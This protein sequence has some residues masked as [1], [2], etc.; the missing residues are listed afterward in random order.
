MDDAFAGKVEGILE[1]SAQLF[2]LNGA[3]REVAVLARSIASVEQT[4]YDNWNGGTSIYTLT[5]R[6]P[7]HLYA[8]VRDTKEELETSI[9]NQINEVLDESHAYFETVRLLPQISSRQTWRENAIEWLNGKKVNNQGRVR[10]DNV[11]SMNSDGLLFR[12]E[13]EIN[14][15]KALKQLGVSF[16][17]LPVFVR[18][19]SK[20]RR[21]EP[22]FVIIKDGVMMV[23][24][25]DGDTVHRE[26][27]AEAHA[28]TVM[29][30]HEGAHIERISA[31]ECD[32]EE[33]AR[34]VAT[35]IIGVISRIKTSR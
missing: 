8:S 31:S 5:L 15:Y 17:P 2:A 3:A 30:S 32:S 6:L 27:P 12:S 20:Y 33:K 9:L 21:I 18:G 35:R 24:E 23:I 14:F 25:V 26:T 11:A 10:S 1:A 4:D 19:G 13:P 22:D 7:I 34:K 16:A 28:R 29:L